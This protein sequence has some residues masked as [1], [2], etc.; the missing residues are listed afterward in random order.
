[1]APHEQR[2][3]L[4]HPVRVA[5]LDLYREDTSRSLAV[6]VLL[7]D[8]RRR[9]DLA[10]QYPSAFRD[11]DAARVKYHLTRLQDVD[12]LPAEGW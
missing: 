12:L 11:L 4:S 3:A 5:I 6:D 1:M 9:K 7:A 10:E 8:L 2:Q